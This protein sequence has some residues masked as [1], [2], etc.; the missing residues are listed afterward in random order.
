MTQRLG[1]AQALLARPDLVLLDEPT[2]ALDPVGRREVRDLIRELAAGGV[3]VFLNS[4]LLTEVEV[5]CDRVAI[6]SQGRVV[7]SGPLDDLAGAVTQLRLLLDRADR[8]LLALLGR[9]GQ[10][11]RVEGTAVTLAVETLDVAPDLARLLVDLRLPAVRA[12]PGAALAGGRL[13]RAGRGGARGMRRAGGGPLDDPRGPP[14]PAGAGRGGPQRRLRGPVRGR[15]SPCSTTARSGAL[16]R[17]GPWRPGS[18]RARSCWPCRPSWSCFG[19]VRR[20][21]SWPPCSRCSWASASVS[22][23][24]D[25][26][27]LH[28]VLA[29]PLSRLEYLAGRFLALAAPAGHLCGR[30]ERRPPAGRPGGR[31]LPAGR[32]HPGGRADGRSR[33]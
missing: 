4:H 8:E 33:C 24:I 10:V 31:R 9:H 23:E 7:A 13:R 17:P 1:L 3:T 11:V 28:A 30:D 2:S 12:G 19:P 32:R 25:S 26:G 14:A 27:A 29:R 18:T 15:R 21:S 5:V 22:P 16:P 6:V 20:S